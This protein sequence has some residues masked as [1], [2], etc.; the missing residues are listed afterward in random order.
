MASCLDKLQL[1]VEVLL[2]LLEG[3]DPAPR[4]NS[5]VGPSRRTLRIGQLLNGSSTPVPERAPGSRLYFSLA[6]RRP[7]PAYRPDSTA[8][9]TRGSGVSDG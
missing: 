6:A 1:E 2:G 9:P 3:S 8:D 4:R 7:R 5:K